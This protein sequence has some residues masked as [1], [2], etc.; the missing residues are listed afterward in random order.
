M[1]RRWWMWLRTAEVDRGMATA[2]YAVC[3]LAA[4]ALAAALY[5]VMTSGTVKEL[6]RGMVEKAL[7]VQF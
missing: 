6:L 2:E 3:T 1:F 4:C 5:A 7:G